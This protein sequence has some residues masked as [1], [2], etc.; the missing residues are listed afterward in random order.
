MKIP[1]FIEIIGHTVHVV[2]MDTIIEDNKELVGLAIFDADKILIGRTVNGIPVS[3]DIQGET[4]LH[5]TVHH[6]NEAFNLGL[7][8]RQVRGVSRGL[9]AVQKNNKLKFYE[10]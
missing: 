4:F 10:D 2:V 1:N 8:E 9:Y 6:I 7:T 5:E 3:T